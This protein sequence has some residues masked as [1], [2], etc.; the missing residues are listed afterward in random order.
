MCVDTFFD[1]LYPNPEFCYLHRAIFVK[2]LGTGQIDTVLLKSVCGVAA[3]LLPACHHSLRE[4]AACWLED[5][6]RDSLSSFAHVSVSRLQALL[7]LVLHFHAVR[8]YRK[9]LFMF[10]HCVRM[11]FLLR[12]N[13][14]DNSQNFL[15]REMRR[16]LMWSIY[17]MDTFLSGGLADFVLC[18][19]DRICIQ[20]PCEEIDFRLARDSKTAHLH[21][22]KGSPPHQI[23]LSALAYLIRVFDIRDRI[24]R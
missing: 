4:S 15:S 16:R 18:P 22:T 5:A 2:M 17:I 23:R 14:E 21:N 6:E 24:L 3:R 11:A 1:L 9:T 13:H 20:L 8:K 7:T 10:S 19:S 12:L